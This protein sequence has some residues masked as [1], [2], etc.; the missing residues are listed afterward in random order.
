MPQL[1]QILLAGGPFDTPRVWT[2]STDED[3]VKVADGSG[4]DHFRLTD[5]YLERNGE[6][7]RVYR[8]RYRTF[9]AE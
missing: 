3:R 1:R 5:E 9:V 4:Y 7:M 6:R 2:L 8:W